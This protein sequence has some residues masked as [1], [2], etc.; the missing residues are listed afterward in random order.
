MSED[1]TLDEFVGTETGPISDSPKGVRLVLKEEYPEEWGFAELDSVCEVNSGFTW[2]KEQ[3]TDSF[4]EGAVP[5]IKIGNVQ[6]GYLDLTDKLYLK[7]VSDEDL[8]KNK[9]RKDWLLM[10]GSN[11]SGERVGHCG[12]IEENM[13]FVYASF[14]YGLRANAE[15]VLPRYLFYTLNRPN[16][17]QRLTS[18][19]AG[20]T[21]LK[22]LNKSTI[23]NLFLPTPPLSEQRKIATVLHTVDQAIQ[24]TEEIIER[25]ER[26]HTGLRRD[27][28][29][30]GIDH[31]EFQKMRIGPF[32]YEI[33]ASWEIVSVDEACTNLDKDRIPVKKSKREEME[34]SIPY[35]GASG[36]I[37]YV[38]DYLFKN[39]L[40][41]LAEDGENLRARNSPISFKI[42]GKAWVNN[43]AHV[44][45]PKKEFVIDY[46]VGYFER[47]NYEPFVTGSAQPKLTQANM[48]MLSVP[49]P[50]KNEQAE[51]SSVLTSISGFKNK[52]EQNVNRMEHLKK[53]LMQDLLSGEVR[54]T[55]V[56]IDI[57][58]KV[59]KYG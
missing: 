47:L 44:F 26:L 58:E 49:K 40:I 34:G 52:L 25:G 55:D 11:G 56:D 20:S 24:K 46:L 30:S 33:P 32:E 38:D 53:G 6:D 8:D 59:A 2:N 5:V 48:E 42:S 22:N 35:Y 54:T 15:Y 41:L 9:I 51:I 18:F 50:P 23:E 57:P 36:I 31:R 28:V 29:I 37:D 7:G 43:H 1:V 12:L 4:E 3:E 10:I 21:S 27:L 45:K 13:E 16:V 19:T 17:Q 39:D 14:L